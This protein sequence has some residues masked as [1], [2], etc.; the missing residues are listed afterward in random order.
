VYYHCTRKKRATP[1]DEKCIEERRLEEQIFTFLRSV[2]LDEHELEEGLKAIEEARKKETAVGGGVRNA[3][4]A[5]LERCTRGLD[6]LTKLFY[7]EL[8]GEDEFVKQR[9]ELVQEREKLNQRLQSLGTEQWIEPARKLFRFNNRAVF[10]L[11]HGTATEKRLIL[12]TI[13]SNP[14]LGSKKLNIYARKPFV[15]IQE[16]GSFCNWSAI[17]NDVRTFLTENPAFVIPALPEPNRVLKNEPIQ[18]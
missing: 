10:W 16:R 6:N 7:R 5:A 12:A 13:G 14:T 11:T 17:V 3:V 8:I 18:A 2:Y 4:E 15:S 1:C 9:A